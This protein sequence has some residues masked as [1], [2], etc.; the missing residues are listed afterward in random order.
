MLPSLVSVQQPNGSS[1]QQQLEPVIRRGAFSDVQVLEGLLHGLLYDHLGWKEGQE[2]AALFVEPLFVGKGD[3]EQ[4]TQLMFEAFN[5]SG[6]FLHDA[7]SLALAA[8]SKL[9]GCTIDIGHG[10]ID[11]ATV[12]DGVMHAP[13]AV[14]MSF[15]GQ[16]LTQ[17]GCV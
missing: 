14:R 11:I 2:G 9:H 1:T 15:A 10:K 4:L 6:L 16:Q 3:R 7:A 17:V 12:S 5:V 13:G 8:N